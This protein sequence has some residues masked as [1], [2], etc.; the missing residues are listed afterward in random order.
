MT[1]KYYTVL[2]LFVAHLIY[3]GTDTTRVGQVVPLLIKQLPA[4]G[5]DSVLVSRYDLA[6]LEF[7]R[8]TLLALDFTDTDELISVLKE[9]AALSEQGR[10]QL[11][12][13]TQT[14]LRTQQ[15]SIAKQDIRIKQLGTLLQHATGHVNSAGAALEQT[16]TTVKVARRRMWWE[17]IG[18]G[19][20]GVALGIVAASTF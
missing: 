9:Q 11:M 3:A 19:L 6:K 13:L 15:D 10:E 12:T 1:T 17:R 7:A 5:V 16:E 20:L 18:S 2:L 4:P 8:Q 14:R